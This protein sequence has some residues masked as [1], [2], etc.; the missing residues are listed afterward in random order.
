[1]TI[2][3]GG[4]RRGHLL[5]RD[6]VGDLAVID[7][8]FPPP[9]ADWPRLLTDQDAAALVPPL[10]AGSHKGTRGRVVVVGGAE[11]MTGAA[12][13]AARA[14]FSAGAGLVHLVAP[15]ASVRVIAAAEPDVQT[16][17]HPLALPL[18]SAVVELLGRADAVVIGPGLGREE[19]RREFV[20]A[21]IAASR[22]VVVL[23]AD[24]IVAFNGSVERLADA[25]RGRTLVLTPH[26]GEYRGLFPAEASRLAVDPWAAAEHAARATGATV[27][28]KGVPTV[29]A[30]PGR[31]VQTV[32]SGNPGLATGGS[33]D[34]LS[35]ILATQ[36][37][38]GLDPVAAASVAAQAMGDAA[39]LAARRTTARSMRPMDVIAALP[40]VW[41]RWEL[42]RRTP[43]APQAPIVHELPAPIRV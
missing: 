29:V 42:L 43:P 30:G 6:E 36:L 19:G 24:G 1:M 40:D 11:G 8:G 10:P 31:P 37:A 35:G 17:A 2:T 7:I 32:A 41:R 21:V 23:D 16:L 3:F 14:G 33:G 34:T 4:Y 28:L 27:L 20:A 9:P 18:S 25:S 13:L 38:Q 15:E 22:G 39:D 26:A 5:A 12:R